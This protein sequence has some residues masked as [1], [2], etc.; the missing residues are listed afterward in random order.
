VIKVTKK[1]KMDVEE[2]ERK[3]ESEIQQLMEHMEIEPPVDRAM[4][5]AKVVAAKREKER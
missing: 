3:P 5:I 2:E 1:E 4:E